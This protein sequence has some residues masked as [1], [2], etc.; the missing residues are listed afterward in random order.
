M[1]PLL[2]NYLSRTASFQRPGS[3][4]SVS[5]CPSSPADGGRDV[6]A[7]L[8]RQ[9]ITPR[10][11]AIC[12]VGGRSFHKQKPPGCQG[13]TS[14]TAASK[15]IKT[16]LLSLGGAGF[17]LPGDVQVEIQRPP[18]HFSPGANLCLSQTPDMVNR[19]H[20]QLPRPCGLDDK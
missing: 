2:A 7:C 18:S 6:K 15:R 12:R 3:T 11:H 9:I 19:F 16:S 4:S 20:P 5:R 8:H 1:T 14:V 13:R 17:F 10:K